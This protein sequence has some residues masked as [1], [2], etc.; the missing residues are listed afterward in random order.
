MTFSW[1]GNHINKSKHFV[2]KT[3]YVKEQVKDGIV[4]IHHVAGVDNC[5]DI[6]TKP[7]SGY[8]LVKHTNTI[9]GYNKWRIVI[10]IL[11]YKREWV[12]IT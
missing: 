10:N 8:L 9:L 1:E 7:L 2:V 11:R 6:Y 4:M 3:A 12:E 5:T